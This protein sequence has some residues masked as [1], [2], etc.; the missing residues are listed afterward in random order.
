MKT[1][2]T[3][4]NED[5]SSLPGSAAFIRGELDDRGLSASQFRVFC[6]IARRGDCWEPIPK[7]ARGCR[8]NEGTVT[9]ALNFLCDCRLIKKMSRPG[10]TSIFKINPISLWEPTRNEGVG[11]KEGSPS[12]S[13]RPTR[14]EGVGTGGNRGGTKLLPQV[15]PERGV[16]LPMF[17]PVKRGL[18]QREYD[19]MIKEALTE[20]KDLI[21]DEQFVEKALTKKALSYIGWLDREPGLKDRAQR[22]KDVE[23]DP[24]NYEEKLTTEGKAHH[25]CWSE[26]I[27]EIRRV[28]RGE[29]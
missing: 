5:E 19:V 25:H 2:E 24:N 1:N 3:T 27:Q 20:L 13:P 22:I 14:N 4:E 29:K 9:T 11:G 10:R 28:K 6:R 15:T 21:F 16:S 18:F 23:A 8:L 26:R 7:F 12:V 17:D